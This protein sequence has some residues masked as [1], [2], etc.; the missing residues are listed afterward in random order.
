MIRN[1]WLNSLQASVLATYR[2]FKR[3]V[4]DDAVNARLWQMLR[5]GYMDKLLATSADPDD[6]PL[7]PRRDWEGREKHM[8]EFHR[9]TQRLMIVRYREGHEF[10]KMRRSVIYRLICK[11]SCTRLYCRLR[12]CMRKQRH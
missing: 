8:N 6:A 10:D 9:H 12:E 3:I 7:L 1:I 5:L 2:A 11:C 4:N